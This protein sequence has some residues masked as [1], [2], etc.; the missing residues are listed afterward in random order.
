VDDEVVVI[1]SPQM[2]H[3]YFSGKSA[4]QTGLS[5]NNN[6]QKQSLIPIHINGHI[7]KNFT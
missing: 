2:K 6:Y 3:F 7:V 4:S 1:V 5:L